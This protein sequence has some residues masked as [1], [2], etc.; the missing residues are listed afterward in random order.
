MDTVAA[1]ANNYL[2]PSHKVPVLRF[3]LTLNFG[4]AEFVISLPLISNFTPTHKQLNPK[5]KNTGLRPWSDRYFC[6][7]RICN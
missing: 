6:D 1:I 5:H 4:T 2:N 3:R 7:G